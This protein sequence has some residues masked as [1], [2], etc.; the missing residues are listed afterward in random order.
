M[1]PHS[2]TLDWKIP[3]TEEPG[4]LQSIGSLRVGHDWATSFSCIGE[5]N[6]NPL[7]CSC[8]ENPRDGAAWWAAVY[9]VAQSRTWLKRLSSSSRVL[10]M[11]TRILEVAILWRILRACCVEKDRRATVFRLPRW[12]EFE[13]LP[14]WGGFR[15]AAL[16][17]RVLKACS[18]ME[19][20]W[21]CN[22]EKDLKGYCVEKNFGGPLCWGGFVVCHAE[23]GLWCCSVGKDSEVPQ[24]SQDFWGASVLNLRGCRT[25]EDSKGLPCWEGFW[26]PAVFRRTWGAASLGTVLKGCSVEKNVSNYHLGRILRGCHFEEDLRGYHVRMILGAPCWE[27]L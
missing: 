23:K 8:L 19:G 26:G 27:E 16:L 2:S 13:G 17:R 7:W 3:W 15:A 22:V 25:L 1:A 9:G 14:C 5:G 11:L 4:G 10:K 12:N 6:G 20:F 18:C 24:C 21:G